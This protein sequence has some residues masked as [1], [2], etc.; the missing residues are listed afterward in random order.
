MKST[1]ASPPHVVRREI[2]ASEVILLALVCLSPW[3]FGCVEARAQLALEVGIVLLAISNMMI[4]RR[5]S[6]RPRRLLGLPSLALAGLALLALAQAIPLPPG[7]LKV[8]APAM[9]S[10]R[11]GLV[12]D[13]PE[14]VRGDA[15]PPVALPA[16]TLSLDPEASVRTAAQLAAAWILFEGVIRLG[17]GISSVRRLGLALVG[18]STLLALFSLIQSLAWN[19]K[20]YGI[21]PSPLSGGQHAG[22]PFVCHNHLAAYLNLGLGFALG[23]LLTR[24]GDAPVVQGRHGRLSRCWGARLWAAYAT[25]LIVLGI[26]VSHSRGGFL[27][28]IGAAILMLLI[29][30]P[31][32]MRPKT[33]LITMSLLLSL[34]LVAVGSASPF[35][36]LAT[37]PDAIA[38]GLRGRAEGLGYRAEVWK[39]AVEAWWAHPIFGTGL[40]SF[41]PATIAHIHRD[42]GT[43]YFHAESEYLQVL[44]EGGAVGLGLALLALAGVAR[45][46][47]RAGATATPRDR[48]LIYGAWFGGLALAIQCL[49]DFPLHIPGVAV[50]AVVLAATLCRLGLDSR[51]DR[52]S[53]VPTPPD[54]A[55]AAPVLASLVMIGIGLVVVVNGIKLARAEARV[56]RAGLPLPGASMP[57]VRNGDLPRSDLERMRTALEHALRSRPNW[58]EG[59]LRLGNTLLGL[60]GRTVREWVG[61]DRQD[62]A[63]SALL[64]DPLWLH[65]VVHSTTPDQRAAV[66]GLFDQEPVRLYLVP[67]ARSFL[68]ARRCSPALALPHLRL[69]SLDYLLEGGDPG[70]VSVERALRL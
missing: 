46:A 6:R 10:F 30:R 27:S 69:A 21:R 42:R 54:P 39:G 29:L 52:E 49:S 68:E 25:G 17:G 51:H 32:V 58:A 53:P 45:L 15:R 31:G 24:E 47:R 1:G 28:M 55:G 20:I 63:R 50:P 8:L 9:H 43:F 19:G 67:A 36:R 2:Q 57:T 5:S 61:E 23:L 26:L 70:T 66:G 40:G 18:N 38:Q 59:H 35:R 4:G 14:R 41:L 62:R 56:A 60:Y 16:D 37:I 65:G 34:F 44:V 64:S 13:V 33:G 12:P 11:M 3:A 48:S 22:G 7:A